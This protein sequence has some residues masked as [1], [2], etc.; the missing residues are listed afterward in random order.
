MNVQV[1]PNYSLYGYDDYS[2]ISGHNLFTNIYGDIISG[3]GSSNLDLQL[4]DTARDKIVAQLEVVK[5]SEESLQDAIRKSYKRNELLR[6]S[7]GYVD[8]DR[9]SDKN[10]EKVLEK[11]SNLLDLTSK[12]NSD[13]KKL[14]DTLK[15]ISVM[16]KD[17]T[18]NSS[19]PWNLS[20]RMKY[21]LETSNTIAYYY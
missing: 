21:P 18:A 17:G 8:I 16:V 19:G 13:S 12:Y 1:I 6:A 5:K 2:T 14:A 9:V 15:K 7:N 3:I 20:L 11:H 10:L 4:T